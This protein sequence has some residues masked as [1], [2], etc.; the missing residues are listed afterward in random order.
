MLKKVT[1]EPKL[2]A[3]SQPNQEFLL[4]EPKQNVKNCEI[5]PNQMK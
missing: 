2:E 5:K 3:F 4:P 1:F